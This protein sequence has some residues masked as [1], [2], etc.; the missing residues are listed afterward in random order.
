MDSL[1]HV[2]TDTTARRS[3]LVGAR[4]AVRLHTHKQIQTGK[5]VQTSAGGT[6]ELKSILTLHG[7]GF[8]GIGCR[9]RNRLVDADRSMYH[10]SGIQPGQ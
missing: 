6:K 3:G 5:Q 4:H 9:I 2:G 8:G 10:V 7:A 1:I